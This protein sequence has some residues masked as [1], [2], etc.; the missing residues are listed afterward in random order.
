MAQGMDGQWGTLSFEIPDFLADA[1][2]SINSVAEVLLAALDI[3]LTALKIGKAYLIAFLDPVIA[4]VQALI[5]ELEGLLK[6]FQSLGYYITGDWKLLNWPFDEL[7]G[8]FSGYERRM[9]SRLTDRTDT[10]RPDIPPTMSV[11]ALFF[12]L[13]VDISE[14]QRLIRFILMLIQFFNQSYLPGGQPVPTITS[15][16][17]GTDT[18]T[19]FQPLSIPEYFQRGNKTPPNLVQVKWTVNAPTKNPFNPFPA[20]PSKG[21]LVTVSTVKD[22]ISVRYD[23][24]SS[25]SGRVD[26]TNGGQVQPREYGVMK[27]TSQRPLTLFGGADMIDLPQELAYNSAIE[28]GELKDGYARVYGA[29]PDGTIVPLEGLSSGETRYFQRTFH[30]P[31]KY[32]ANQW[33]AGNEYMITLKASEMPLTGTIHAENDGKLTIVDGQATS[34]FYVRVASCTEEIGEETQPYIYDFNPLIPFMHG[35]LVPYVPMRVGGVSDAS[36][37]S[38][39][40]VITF[41]NVFTQTYLETVQVALAV[42]FLSRPDLVPLDELEGLL[43]KEQKEGI[44]SG[45]LLF[46]HVALKRC[47]LESVQRLTALLYTNYSQKIEERGVPLHKFRK[48]LAN[49]VRVAANDIYTKSGPMPDAEEAIVKQTEKLRTVTWGEIFKE[50][51]PNLVDKLGDLKDKTILESIQSQNQTSGV[52]LNPYSMGLSESSANALFYAPNLVQ[53]RLPQMMEVEAGSSDSSWQPLLEV[54]AAEAEEFMASLSPALLPIYEKYRQKDG[55]IVVSGP[56]TERIQQLGNSLR[57]EGSADVSPVVYVN[58][59][60]LNGLT[61]GDRPDLTKTGVFYIRGI[62]AKFSEGEIFR[63]SAIAL[64]IGGAAMARS[65]SDGEWLS[66]RFFDQ[67]PSFQEFF[68][69][70]INWVKAIAA[71]LQSVVDAILKYIEFVEARIVEFQQ[72]I[73][74]INALLQTLQGFSFKIPKCSAL[75]LTSNGTDGILSGLI[76]AGSKPSDSPLAY[77]AGIVVV[78]PFGPA[79][80]MDM[81]RAIFVTEE[82]APK[83]GEMMGSETLPFPAAVGIEGLPTPTPPDPDAPPD[84]L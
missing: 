66:V 77:G 45:T 56:D 42:L 19:I 23:R 27:D 54:S 59:N 44:D 70:L 25:N 15:I 20:L 67:F 12:Y 24:P 64:S 1:R 4:L 78:I 63:Q 57:K 53:D 49:R 74:R 41:P 39:A 32:V 33:V 21:F 82:G 68:Q 76:S 65:P 60:E 81:L 38:E 75:A 84:V 2:E 11:L 80:V 47:S 34:T 29:F 73:Q 7:K 16:K 37:F 30:V 8:G 52:A 22:G 35:Q 14:I 51:H 50:T 69:Q 83:E 6:S 13:S 18:A 46:N 31:L 17:Y 28:N 79:F 71:S 40:G 5:D 9:I 55:S 26:G 3:A 61:I 43:T 62:F 58:R 48:D 36:V 72:L 10:T